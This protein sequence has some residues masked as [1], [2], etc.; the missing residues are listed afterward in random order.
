MIFFCGS[1]GTKSLMGISIQLVTHNLDFIKQFFIVKNKQKNEVKKKEKRLLMLLNAFNAFRQS[2]SIGA[3]G[4]QRSFNHKFF[5]I[6]SQI[7]C[8][9]ITN[10][11]PF[12]HK[13][14]VFNHIIF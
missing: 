9:S 8:H 4:F 12:N 13:F 1:G 3:Q 10:S 14:F 6:Q 5:A 7:L 11:L 2:E